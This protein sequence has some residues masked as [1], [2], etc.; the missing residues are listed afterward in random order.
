MKFLNRIPFPYF[1]NKLEKFNFFFGICFFFVIFIIFHRGWFF[2]DGILYGRNWDFSLPDYNIL[3]GKLYDLSRY[4]YH[5]HFES[6]SLL[7][8]HLPHNFLYSII[9]QFISTSVLNKF[10]LFVSNLFSFL[11][12]FFLLKEYSR[13]YISFFMAIMYSFS[14][15]FF[16][17]VIAGSWYS[18]VSYSIA[19]FFIF[20]I[21]KFLY[22]GKYKF[23]LCAGIAHIF[24]IGFLQ[25]YLIVF[26]ITV[27][28]ALSI[29]M[30]YKIDYCVLVKR[31]LIIFLFFS[32]L[33]AY[34]LFPLTYDFN[35]FYE[36]TIN[37]NLADNFGDVLFSGQNML[38]IFDLTGFLNRHFYSLT[39]NSNLNYILYTLSAFSVYLII[40]INIFS[41]NAKHKNLFLYLLIFL[42]LSF[43]LVKGNN[44]PFGKLTYYLFSNFSIMQIYRSPQNLY[45]LVNLTTIILLGLSLNNNYFL[46]RYKTYTYPVGFI[47]LCFFLSGWILNPDLGSNSLSKK[48]NGH[49]SLYSANEDIREKFHKNIMDEEINNELFIPLD[50]SVMFLDGS[51]GQGNEPNLAYLKNTSPLSRYNSNELNEIFKENV[52]LFLILFHN[53]RTIS[54][55]YDIADHFKNFSLLD[56]IKLKNYVD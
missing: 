47:L 54:I 20:F 4:S 46:Y 26:L 49:I 28:W 3:R 7:A 16:S 42:V 11:G 14:P 10:I 48:K 6:Q 15:F 51:T 53:I 32:L 19:P 18:W 5:T 56:K 38:K 40:A 17:I 25:Y 1:L 23:L 30:N 45:F 22:S 36:S 55:R 29:K 21:I 35:S 34:W 44:P 12:M 8:S 2:E 13:K 52:P 37:N 33:S 39:F 43:L 50:K 9:P 31:I 41:K 24:L 27:L